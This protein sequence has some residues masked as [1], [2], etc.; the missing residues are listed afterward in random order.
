MGLLTK[1]FAGDLKKLKLL[2]KKKLITIK[3]YSGVRLMK[4]LPVRGQRTHTNA[5]TAKKRL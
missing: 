3:S 2:F 4:G 1:K 5:I